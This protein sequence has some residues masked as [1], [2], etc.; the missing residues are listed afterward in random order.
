VDNPDNETSLGYTP[1]PAKGEHCSVCGQAAQRKVEETIFDDDPR[2]YVHPLTTYLCLEHFNG[3]MTGG[4]QGEIK[5]MREGYMEAARII[6]ALVVQQGGKV[7]L[8]DV[9]AMKDYALTMHIPSDG[10]PCI[11]TAEGKS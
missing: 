5:A 9:E 11:I 7:Q 3:L 8:T 4:L 2:V 10:E 6:A 1:G